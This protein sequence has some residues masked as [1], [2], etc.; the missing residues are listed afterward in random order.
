M[1]PVH[2]RLLAVQGT[3]LRHH[4]TAEEYGRNVL[5]RQERTAAG[6]TWQGRPP[7]NVTK[8]HWPLGTF[9]LAH[10]Q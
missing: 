8:W 2:S 5:W 7:Q 3:E 1:K 6:H 4:K 9:S 10:Q